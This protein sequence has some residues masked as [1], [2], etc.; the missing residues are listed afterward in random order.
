MVRAENY[1]K[2]LEKLFLSRWHEGTGRRT[3]I[4]EL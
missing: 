3:N 2:K 1:E 4:Q